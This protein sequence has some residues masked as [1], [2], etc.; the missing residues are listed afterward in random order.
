MFSQAK[1]TPTPAG[2]SMGSPLGGPGAAMNQK[3]KP[4]TPA[5]QYQQ[6][7]VTAS[8]F[9]EDGRGRIQREMDK[10][11]AIANNQNYFYG[12]F[13]VGA[14]ALTGCCLVIGNRVPFFRSYC[15]WIAVLGGY[16]G[17]KGATG[18]QSQYLLS[19]VVKQVDH[20]ISETNRM[21]EQT[22]SVVPDYRREAERLTNI[23]YELMPTL[24]EAIEASSQKQ[25][26][27]TDDMADSLIDAYKKRKAA[28][29][30]K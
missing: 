9:I 3:A 22:S 24:P 25:G 1:C 14:V 2:F 30:G 12:Y 18:L 7:V 27:S 20:E 15:G 8:V 21:D 6:A 28:L 11:S 17:A 23:K 16:L 29:Q 10:Y 4:L 5:E 19:K 26:K 13:G